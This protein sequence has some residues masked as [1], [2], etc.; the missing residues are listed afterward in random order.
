MGEE[1]GDKEE[2]NGKEG[3]LASLRSQ[4]TANALKDKKLKAKA[5][6]IPIYRP[7]KKLNKKN[8]KSFYKERKMIKKEEGVATVKKDSLKIELQESLKAQLAKLKADIHTKQI[9][10]KVVKQKLE[11]EL[12]D[13]LRSQLAAVLPSLAP[14]TPRPLDLMLDR[15]DDEQLRQ[16]LEEQLRALYS[17]C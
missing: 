11:V 14:T 10:E 6:N 2:D 4:I 3:L 16:S 1:A 12:A 17:S 9:N 15:M 5:N 8:V 7:R 13:S